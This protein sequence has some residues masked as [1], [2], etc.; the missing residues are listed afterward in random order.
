MKT[1]LYAIADAGGVPY[2]GTYEKSRHAAWFSHIKMRFDIPQY[3]ISEFFEAQVRDAKEKG[4][5][6]IVCE[7]EVPDSNIKI[8]T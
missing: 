5:H 7:V 3:M 1:I 2:H 4:D 8:L 6:E